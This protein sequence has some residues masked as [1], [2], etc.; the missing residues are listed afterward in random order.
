MKI[1]LLF[2]FFGCRLT[3][4]FTHIFLHFPHSQ[5]QAHRTFGLNS[6]HERKALIYSKR[7]KMQK[8]GQISVYEKKYNFF[9]FFFI[10]LLKGKV[11]TILGDV[12]VGVS[13]YKM[14]NKKK[15]YKTQNIYL[16]YS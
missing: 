6:A 1:L 16:L 10:Y 8:L 2:V 12:C 15:T 13:V 5:P 7:M 9:G 14:Y 4:L 3:I 11:H